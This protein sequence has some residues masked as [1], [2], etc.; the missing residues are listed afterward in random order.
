MNTDG[1]M[2][3]FLCERVFDT[4]DRLMVGSLISYLVTDVKQNTNQLI[5]D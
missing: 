4:T 1:L 2:V 5:E 3:G